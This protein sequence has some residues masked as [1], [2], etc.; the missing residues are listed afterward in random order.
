[1]NQF[2]HQ[3]TRNVVAMLRILV[4][5]DNE[6]SCLVWLWMVKKDKT[7]GFKLPPVVCMANSNSKPYL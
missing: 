6:K 3:S 1:M 2:F 5:R 4:A 7:G